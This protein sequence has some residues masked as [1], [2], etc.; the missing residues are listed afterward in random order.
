VYAFP[1]QYPVFECSRYSNATVPW[2][3]SAESPTIGMKP[4]YSPPNSRMDGAGGVL[5]SENSSLRGRASSC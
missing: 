2:I 1:S 3:A 5:H 4:A